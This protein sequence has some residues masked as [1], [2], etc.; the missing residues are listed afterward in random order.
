MRYIGLFLVAA[1]VFIAGCAGRPAPPPSPPPTYTITVV[2]SRDEYQPANSEDSNQLRLV[3]NE[4][5]IGEFRAHEPDVSFTI[6]DEQA[7]AIM[8]KNYQWKRGGESRTDGG[9]IREYEG[10]KRVLE[11]SDSSKDVK[12][13]V[14]TADG[15]KPVASNWWRTG[16]GEEAASDDANQ[17][18]EEGVVHNFQ[19]APSVPMR[20]FFFY[21]DNRRNRVSSLN[22][23]G[24][25]YP[26]KSGPEY[27]RCYASHKTDSYE[28]KIGEK[29]LGNV[30]WRE[31]QSHSF[32]IDPGGGASYVMYDVVYGDGSESHRP[33]VVNL[34]NSFLH[35]L[36]EG[37]NYFLE[38]PP[39]SI[40]TI[41]DS[42]RKV[43]IEDRNQR[44]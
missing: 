30:A 23:E 8:R 42:M 15:W 6:N 4:N 24:T 7:T 34:S 26:V 10:A 3:I 44:R 14:K 33:K 40:I 1:I 22:F 20:L 5:V 13:E 39:E 9:R 28:L 32:L 11:I 17:E 19:L 2:N 37:C 18:N 41:T 25:E 31:G 35:R 16:S 36:P 21:V 29:S 43:V 38:P 12:V 27:L